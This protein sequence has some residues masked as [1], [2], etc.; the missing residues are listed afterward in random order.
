MT[1]TAMTEAAEFESIYNLRVVE[2]PTNVPA[3]RVDH[4]DEIYRT[5]EEKMDAIVLQVEE[6]QRRQQ[7]VLVGTT[8][9]E[10]SERL[11]K[12]LKK[13]GITHN[14]LN[15]RYHE[16]EAEIIA[17]AG[18]PGAVTIATNMA[19]RGTDIKLG[20]NL[21]AR[22][23][24]EIS[25]ELSAEV[26]AQKIAA[27]QKE[28]DEA[29]LVV[30]EA[31]GL[32][33]IG[34]ER[35]ESRRIDN[36]LRGRSGRQGD[37]GAS[38]FFISLEDDLMRIFG[39]DIM[40]KVLTTMRI[41]RGQAI[42]HPWLNSAIERA[43]KKVENQHFEVRKNLLKFD[44][45]MNDQRKV[46]YEQRKD[47][48]RNN[49][50]SET[51][52]DMRLDVIED[53]VL[54]SIPQGSYAEQWDIETLKHDCHRILGLHLPLA[55]WAKE[56]G[57]GDTE[58]L[59]RITEASEKHMAD[60]EARFTSTTMRL[61]EKNILLQILDSSW[62]EHLLNLE[63]VR[64]AIV[65]RAF[66][67]KDPLN[68]Y[69]TEAF[70]MFSSMLE[71]VREGVTTALSLIEMRSDSPPPVIQEPQTPKHLVAGRGENEFD[72]TPERES[73]AQT[74]VNV[75]F[76]PQDPTTWVNTPR[77]APCPCGSGKKYKH[78]HGKAL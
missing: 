26:R 17:E 56:E 30:K 41:E 14:V 66:G 16:Q 72:D 5:F 35:H 9:I 75:A 37:K 38:K 3:I 1:G 18:R 76:N 62:K 59:E 63:Y 52:R 10:K 27:I 47:I 7:P 11:S 34:S 25:P 49:D 32:F 28:I 78:C 33:V 42:M 22:I 64:H 77:N 71:Q 54:K 60:K 73:G 70:G 55:D 36:Q 40:D 50:V 20:G 68:E 31:G 44:N 48:M 2:I 57:V 53:I 6:C 21:E 61:I 67:Q 15:A 65:L 24:K 43:Q 51:V 39:G 4:N 46:I 45:V 74:V 29:A 58:I 13:K 19:G 23:K 69:K 12:H 8:S